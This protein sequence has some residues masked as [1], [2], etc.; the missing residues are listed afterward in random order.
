MLLK[1]PNVPFPIVLINFNLRREENLPTKDKMVDP[2]VSFSEVPLY[3]G[4][5]VF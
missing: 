2:N 5:G 4:V 1:V 3:S